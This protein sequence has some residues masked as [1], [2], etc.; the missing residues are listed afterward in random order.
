MTRPHIVLDT[1]VISGGHI[2][3]VEQFI[4]GLVQGLSKLDGDERYTLVTNPRDPDWIREYAS[5]DMTVV[6]RDDFVDQVRAKIGPLDSVISPIARFII[7]NVGDG[8]DTQSERDSDNFYSSLDADLVH[9]PHQHYRQ[10][11]IPTI[12][13]PHDFQHKK[14][15]EFF[16]PDQLADRRRTYGAGCRDSVAIDV[17]SIDSKSDVVST[18]DVDPD[19]VYVI[20][21]GPPT[22]LYTYP[23]AKDQLAMMEKYDLPE[24]YAFYPAKSWPHKNHLRLVEALGQLRDQRNMTV[25][26][27]LTGSKSDHWK[28]IQD[29]IVELNLTEQVSHLGYVPPEDLRALYQL[30][31]FVVFPSLFEGGG[32]PLLEA[33]SERTPVICANSTALAEKSGDAAISFDPEDVDD[34]AAAIARIHTDNRLYKKLVGLGKIRIDKFNWELTARCYQALYLSITGATL[35]DRQRNLLSLARRGALPKL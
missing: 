35:S 9:F 31:S 3:G 28:T 8:F 21:R 14:Y 16:S 27:V 13:N 34:I 7:D 12:F 26:L 19:S 25:K 10:T 24:R 5:P 2:G 15:P 17:P 22:S 32:F 33:W 23:E 4:A 29:R 6:P 30:A 1:A 20:P 11:S 18:Y